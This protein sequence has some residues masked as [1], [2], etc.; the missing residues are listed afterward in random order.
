MKTKA[1]LYAE[2]NRRHRRRETAAMLAV[3]ALLVGLGLVLA[4]PLIERMLP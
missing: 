2:L 4:W 3:Y 1:Q